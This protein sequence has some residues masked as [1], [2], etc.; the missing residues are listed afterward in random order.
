MIERYDPLKEEMYQVLDINGDIVSPE[1]PKFSEKELKKLYSL[2]VLS[3]LADEKSIKL[4]RQGRMGTFAPNLGHEAAQVGCAFSIQKKDWVFPYFRDLGL[5]LTLGLPLSRYFV[6]WMGNEKGMEIPEGLNLF[7]IAIPVASQLPHAAGAGLSL[8]LQKTG[9]AVLATMG[10]GATSEGDFH[11]AMNFAG[12]FQTPNVFVCINNQWAI[13]LPR[14]KQTASKTLAQKALAYGFPGVM[15]DGNDILAVAS[16]TKEALD[17]A[18]KGK[19]P[20][21]IEAFTYRM[22]NH[23]TADDATKYRTDDELT[24]W[25]KKDPILRFQRYLQKKNI[26]TDNDENEVL[27]SSQDIINRALEEAEKTEPPV[28]EDLFRFLYAEMPPH[29]QEQLAELKNAVAETDR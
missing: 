21:L 8:K 1:E 18:R 9:G 22:S 29:L 23:T 7:S 17:R 19:G 15:V 11:E 10:D 16:A 27:Q 20:T 12:V 2:M 4:Q 25:K 5:Y 13:S 14:K 6:Y 28:M 3:R 26:L 24:A